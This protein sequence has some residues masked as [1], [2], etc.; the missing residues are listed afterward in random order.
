MSKTWDQI[1]NKREDVVNA[2][3]TL[4]TE[5]SGDSTATTAVTNA[6]K[7]LS[8]IKT[9]PPDP[10]TATALK[11]L[12]DAAAAAV[13]K[14][15][16]APKIEVSLTKTTSPKFMHNATKAGI[17]PVWTFGFKDSVSGKAG[18][19]DIHMTSAMTKDEPTAKKMMSD[20]A[21]AEVKKQ[22][23]KATVS[24]KSSTL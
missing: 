9:W 20:A 17:L 3:K 8:G 2:L 4:K 11:G 10:G 7:K 1:K 22:Y 6:E 24:V 19:V 18:S 23:P 12:Y 16:D 13:K 15:V 21:I 14:I 5:A